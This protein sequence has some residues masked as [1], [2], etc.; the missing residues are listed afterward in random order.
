MRTAT[1]TLAGLLA[2]AATSRAQQADLLLVNGRVYT[3][4]PAR[5]WAEA[6]RRRPL[7]SRRGA[8]VRDEHWPALV[9]RMAEALPRG[10]R[11][12]ALAAIHVEPS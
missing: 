3:V 5:P 8:P 11:P 6:L 4:D 10:R 1:A 9:R 7:R 2:C 12:V